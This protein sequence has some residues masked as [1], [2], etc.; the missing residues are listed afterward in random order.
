VR[1]TN[2]ARG[3]PLMGGEGA[4]VRKR[5]ETGR[6]CWGRERWWGCRRQGP[7]PSMQTKTRKRAAGG[8]RLFLLC[9]LSLGSS[10]GRSGGARRRRTPMARARPSRLREGARGALAADGRAAAIGGEVAG[11][12]GPEREGQTEPDWGRG[13]LQNGRGGRKNDRTVSPGNKGCPCTGR[14]ADQ[15]RRIERRHIA[16]TRPRAG[17]DGAPIGRGECGVRCRTL[18]LPFERLGGTALCLSRA[19]KSLDP[20]RP[21]ESN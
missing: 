18:S 10:A 7:A 19:P 16:R 21:P 20:N 6:R 12:R 9:L 3:P 8:S 14:L 11:L 1:H 13:Q 15:D 2:V 5:G 4:R 17:L